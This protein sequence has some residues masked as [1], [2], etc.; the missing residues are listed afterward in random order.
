MSH[1]N[2]NS[3]EHAANVHEMPSFETLIFEEL[4]EW[5]YLEGENMA[6]TPGASAIDLEVE[7]K[8][9]KLSVDCLDEAR[10]GNM[11]KFARLSQEN[12]MHLHREV[13]ELTQDPDVYD[14]TRYLMLTHDILK[15]ETI[16]HAMRLGPEIDHD[17]AY[18]LLLND[19]QY[20]GIR[21]H[22]MPSFD[23]LSV[24]SQDLVLRVSSVRS[25]YPQTLQGE[26]PAATLE[27]FHN[28]QDPLI[29][30]ID[31][32]LKK[33]D[34]FGAT[35]HINQDVS[36]T[37]TDATYRRMCNL[38]NALRDPNLTSANERNETFLMGEFAD[39]MGLH[40]PESPEMRQQMLAV[41]R[42][43]C[44]LRIEDATGFTKLVESFLSQPSVVREILETE[45]SREKRA[46]LAAYSP[47]FVRMLKERYDGVF[48]LTYFAHVL[49]E[50]HIADRGARE[51]GRDGI[52]IVQLDDLTRKLADGKFDPKLNSVRFVPRGDALI[53]E[54]LPASL[55]T[56][57][58]VPQFEDGER[59]RGKRIVVV[60]EGG[61]FDGVQAAMV[62]KLLAH[63]YGAKIAGIV[64]V[65]NEDCRVTNAGRQ[66]GASTYEITADT[67]AVGA[68]R[69]LEKI[70]LEGANPSPM[71]LLNSTQHDRVRDDM[72]TLV[73]ELSADIVVGVG[74]AGSSLWRTKHPNFSAHLPT[75]TTPDQDYTVMQSLAE[76]AASD[77]VEMF[78]VIVAPGVDSPSY[79]RAVMDKIGAAQ[80][81]L[82]IEDVDSIVST[83]QRW[84][85]DGSGSQDGRYGEIPL[86]W[87]ASLQRRRGFQHLN[88]PRANVL[89]NT[90]P[91]RA[92]TVITP[93]M[94]G[95]VIADMSRHA[96]AIKRPASAAS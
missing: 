60:G 68:G 55:E 86:M 25:N 74:S 2:Y 12:Q 38:D 65:R 31:I 93:A 45:L 58:G 16:H 90:N 83:Y 6:A 36:L 49:Q 5:A 19:P 56:L 37:A 11:R 88:L 15:N 39:F 70:P 89:S 28:E 87:L 30:D 35:G 1:T 62:G 84:R 82:D 34:I 79:A 3:F 22:Y 71:Y 41:A 26:A 94:A 72:H 51:A 76:L 21:K 40:T 63:K 80:I 14:A 18:S 66:I 4:S 44:H 23:V 29:R 9:T 43:S 96:R 53:A 42:L 32:V 46:T 91:L 75:D 24:R 77:D 33:F 27:D 59:F 47:D 85:M 57:D 10:E 61:E 17:K 81:P 54:P 78:S 67:E 7:K 8:R 50:A 73:G 48:A 69:F 64:S 92:F 52:A 20:S 13:A 95:I